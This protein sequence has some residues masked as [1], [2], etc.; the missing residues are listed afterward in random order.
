MGSPGVQKQPGWLAANG[1]K[2]LELLFRA[3]LYHPSQAILIADND[4]NY[5]DAN[6]G[7]GRLL[8]LSRDQIIGRKCEDFAEAAFRTR[9][10]QLWREF[11]AQGEQEGSFPLLGQDENVRDVAYTAKGNILPGQHLVVLQ[12]KASKT[13]EED[14]VSSCVKDYAFFLLDPEGTVVSCYSGAER[15]YGYK[16]SEIIG[17][18]ISYLYPGE[19][20]LRA[21]LL[22][23]LKRIEA[24][25]HFGNEDW[26]AKK[27]G[28]RF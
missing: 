7:A 1:L 17:R 23:E 10:E 13:P 6:A 25:G 12:E 8:G 18:H 20:N 5:L 11:L 3:V 21:R 14:A 9:V 16:D 28:S 26:H 19:D 2:E 4:R 15:I 24:Q 22:G 27:D